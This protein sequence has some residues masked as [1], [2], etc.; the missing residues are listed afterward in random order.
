MSYVEV[1]MCLSAEG[2]EHYFVSST[3]LRQYLR[4]FEFRYGSTFRHD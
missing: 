2:G 4:E 3:S 1:L